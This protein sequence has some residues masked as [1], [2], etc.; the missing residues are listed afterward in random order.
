MKYFIS[1]PKSHKTDDS[2]INGIQPFGIVNPEMRLTISGKVI[3]SEVG[4]ESICIPFHI[5][6]VFAQSQHIVE[7]LDDEILYLRVGEVKYPLLA[8]LKYVAIATLYNP[9][10]MRFS[11]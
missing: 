9:V 2:I 3:R 11:K 8:Y 10:G 7:S 4:D 5:A 6:D 1:K